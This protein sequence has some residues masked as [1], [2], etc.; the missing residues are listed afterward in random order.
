MKERSVH[1]TPRLTAALDLLKGSVCVADIGCD[2]GRLAASLLQ[3]NICE[4]VVASDVSEPSLQKAKS[5]LTYIGVSDRVSFRCGDGLSMLTAGECDAVAILGMGGTLMCRL[6]DACDIPLMGAKKIVLQPMRAQRDIRAYL[7]RHRY[8]ITD[9]RIVREGSRLYQVFRAVLADSV[10]TWPQGFP[11][12]FFDVG[13]T[14]FL[15]RE[16]NLY[17]L[18]MQQRDQHL[19]RLKTAQHTAGEN[20]L[21]ERIQALDRIIEQL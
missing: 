7:Y 9:D 8:Q 3:Q 21:T 1:L 19:K 17:A 10:Q 15:H 11:E 18:C 16:P 2:H 5:L 14:A 13:Y 6:L 4:R 20:A 12:G